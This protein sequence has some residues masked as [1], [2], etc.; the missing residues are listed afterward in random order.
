[1]A[2]SLWNTG[3]GTSGCQAD[4]PAA[5]PGSRAARRSPHLH[6][7]EPA[8]SRRHQPQR[9]Q[10]AS[11]SLAGNMHVCELIITTIII[12]S[13]ARGD[14]ICLR[15]L[16]VSSYLFASWHLFWHVGYLRYQQQVDL[17]PF[18]IESGV[19]IT[20]DMGYLCA[21]FSLPRPRV[22]PDVRRQSGRQDVRQKHRLMPPPYGGGGIINGSGGCRR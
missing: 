8:S 11:A 18:D 2:S 1:M 16:Q 6:A 3:T 13:C 21:N 5:E 17:W 20:C 4:R 22:R 19:R 7:T 9:L 12:T 10:P 14:T 15:P